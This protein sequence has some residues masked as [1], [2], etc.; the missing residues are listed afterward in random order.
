MALLPHFGLSTASSRSESSHRAKIVKDDASICRSP[1]ETMRQH[2]PSTSE[3]DTNVTGAFCHVALRLKPAEPGECAE[4]VWSVDSEKGYITCADS[5]DKKRIEAFKFDSVFEGSDNQ[6][7][8]NIAVNDLVKECMEGVDATALAYGQTNSGKTFSMMGCE[9]QPGIIPQ[10]INDVF[11]YIRDQSDNREFLLRASYL[12][13]YNERIRDLLAPEQKEL[14]LSSSRTR[15]VCVS[16]LREEIVTSPMQLMKLIKT[17]ETNRSSS[18]TEVNENSSRSHTIF[19]L[20]IES[21]SLSD[22]PEMLVLQS[23]LNLIDLAGSEKA[24]N[25]TD[26]RKESSFINKS[27]LTLGI[28]IAK[29]IQEVPY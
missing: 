16:N 9:E 29:I 21:R 15:L 5:P 24:T 6:L 20:T 17:G 10:A 4:E 1:V 25:D 19:Q 3:P 2:S 23:Q 7:L 12:E 8:Y 22:A 28:V 27:L 13:I 26:R 18:S 14:R 11:N